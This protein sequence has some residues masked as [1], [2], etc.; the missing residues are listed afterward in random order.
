MGSAVH[1]R[2]LLLGVILAGIA[3]SWASQPVLN[4]YYEAVYGAKP[5]AKLT[6]H[7]RS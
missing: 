2:V 6:P 7:L 1:V 3:L 4:R 5:G